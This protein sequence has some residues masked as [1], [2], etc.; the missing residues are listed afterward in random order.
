[1]RLINNNQYLRKSR[2][3]TKGVFGSACFSCKSV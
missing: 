1:M 2:V 3:M